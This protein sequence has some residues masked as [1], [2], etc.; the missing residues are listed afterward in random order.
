MSK[1]TSF[2]CARVSDKHNGWARLHHWAYKTHAPRW[3][4]QKAAAAAAAGAGLLKK[5]HLGVQLFDLSAVPETSC[6][7]GQ[8]S[9]SRGHFVAIPHEVLRVCDLGSAHKSITSQRNGWPPLTF[10][11]QRLATQRLTTN[12]QCKEETLSRGFQ[13]ARIRML[14]CCLS[15]CH[16]FAPGRWSL[17]L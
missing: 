7:A 9:S 4:A 2:W 10:V 1:Q 11:R 17:V 16:R 5:A 8:S 12:G 13:L 15:R 3:V 14:A 6:N